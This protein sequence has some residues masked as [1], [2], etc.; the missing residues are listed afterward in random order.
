MSWNCSRNGAADRNRFISAVLLK[1]DYYYFSAQVI[2][3]TE[4]EE[5]NW[6]ETVNAGMTISPGGL[7]PQNCCG[8]EEEEE[9]EFVLQT[10]IQNFQ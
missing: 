4:G 5:K 2:S 10:C 1:F 8:E 9:E 7:P 3:D 6:L